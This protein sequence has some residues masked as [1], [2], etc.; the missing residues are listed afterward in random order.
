MRRA[1]ATLAA[2]LVTATAW[3]AAPS[4]TAAPIPQAAT[5][6][7]VWVVVGGSVRCATSHGDGLSALRSAGFSPETTNG[8]VCRIDGSPATCTAPL[9]AYWSY[10][11]AKRNTDGTYGAWTY[12]N[13]GASQFKPTQGDAEGWAFGD[14][15]TPPSGRP[16][17]SPRTTAPVAPATSAPVAPTGT[18]QATSHPGTS[19]EATSNQGGSAPATTRTTAAASGPSP[20]SSDA[21]ATPD[22]TM[23]PAPTPDGGTS[24]PPATV[25]AE[26]ASAGPSGPATVVFVAGALA[27]GGV[28]VGWALR[29]RRAA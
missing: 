23:S 7:G 5:C 6:S 29:R 19:T 18:T 11:H 3:V 24:T 9:T 25:T 26:V 2:L 21:A 14:G 15:K 10:W 22:A 13:K 17:V 8:M 12:S 28:G 27:L 1:L 20:A 4:A 16:P